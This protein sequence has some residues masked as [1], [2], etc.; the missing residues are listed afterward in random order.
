[1]QTMSEFPA[2]GRWNKITTFHVVSTG[3]TGLNHE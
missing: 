1:M 3:E 2:K